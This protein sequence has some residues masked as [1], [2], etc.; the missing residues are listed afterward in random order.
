MP[1]TQPI[2][3]LP[4]YNYSGPVPV[5]PP[6][7]EP[8]GA[9]PVPPGFAQGIPEWL[10]FLIAIGVVGGA[11]SLISNYNQKAGYMFVFLVLL[12]YAVGNKRYATLQEFFNSITNVATGSK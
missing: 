4:Q 10:A 12:G 6:P 11:A 3:Q 5:E 7:P 1:F 8:A 9:P 2:L